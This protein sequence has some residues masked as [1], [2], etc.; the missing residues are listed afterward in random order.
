[1]DPGE[2]LPSEHERHGHDDLPLDAVCEHIDSWADL[3]L[4]L[5]DG[6]LPARRAEA[7]NGHLA[8]CAACRTAL[9]EQRGL[10]LL[11][12]AVPAAPVPEGILDTVLAHLSESSLAGAEAVAD[13]EPAG[14]TGS[15]KTGTPGTRA[16][17][18]MLSRVR[19]LMRP[20]VWLPAAAFALLL[21]VAVTSYQSGFG[22]D[23]GLRAADTGETLKTAAPT[24]ER[25][26][27][28]DDGAALQESAAVDTTVAAASPTTT[29]ASSPTV[30][31]GSG[32]S[33]D[34]PS[35]QV[36]A[37]EGGGLMEPPV[38]WVTVP[39]PSSGG[40]DAVPALT[41]LAD[42]P[43]VTP[44]PDSNGLPAYVALV[45][46]A[47]IDSLTA[48]LGMSELRVFALVESEGLLPS[49]I[50]ARLADGPATLPRLQPSADEAGNTY[51]GPSDM[52][53]ADSQRFNGF[54]IL[55]ITFSPETG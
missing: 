12:R 17:A 40:A 6:S 33:F 39:V 26:L 55:V 47:E 31:A 5:L 3:A 52:P 48:V 22:G 4:D 28:E 10:A 14:H 16:E 43:P 13:I 11:L 20:R 8:G 2:H 24:S 53:P 15:P 29:L 25:A 23:D 45:R 37:L 44:G 19:A 9:D 41:L 51:G 36:E 30:A 38:V 32:P 54:V 46:V 1:M 7:L 27:T 49:E 35:V 34:P 50:A 42:L 18:G 21:G